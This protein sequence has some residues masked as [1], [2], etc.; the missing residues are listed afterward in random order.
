MACPLW[1]SLR[2]VRGWEAEKN[3]R[4]D[5]QDYSEFYMILIRKSR[6]NYEIRERHERFPEGQPPCCPR[7]AVVG[8]FG[9]DGSRAVPVQPRMARPRFSRLPHVAATPKRRRA[10]ALQIK[11]D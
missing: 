4:Q 3:F 2:A 5:E 10:A 6:F 8:H 9:G 1:R 11:A 7:S